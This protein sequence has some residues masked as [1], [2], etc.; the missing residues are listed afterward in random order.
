MIKMAVYRHL[1]LLYLAVR[2]QNSTFTAKYK[3]IRMNI[4]GRKREQ[5][6]LKRLQESPNSEFVM[7]Y[8]RRRVGKTYLIREFFHQQ[9]DFYLTGIA[10]GNRMEQLLNF[11]TT[12]QQYDE[13]LGSKTPQNWFEAFRLLTLLLEKSTNKRKV[14]FLDELPW[15]DTSKS[16]FLKALEHFWNT[17]ASARTDIL[18]IVCGSAASWMVK[19]IVRNHGGLHNRLTYKM[20]LVPFTLH[21]TEE[22]LK[23]LGIRWERSMIAECYMILGGIPY[24]LKLLDKR[25]SLAQNID[26]LFFS[27]SALLEDEFSNLYASLFRNS[28]E[29]IRIIEALAKKKSGYTREEI[30]QQ[31]R[32]SDGGGFSRRLEELEQCGFIRKYRAAGEVKALYQLIDF[33][34]LFYFRFLKKGRSFDNDTWMHLTGTPAYTTWCGLSFEHL[35]LA[36]LEQLKRALGIS[37]ISTNTFAYYSKEAQIDLLID[38][39]DKIMTLCEMKFTEEPFCI[40]KAY[41]EKLEKKRCVVRQVMKRRKGI[42]IVMV[43]ACGLKSNEYAI[44]LVQQAL[45]LNDLFNE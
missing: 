6:E 28:E 30:L 35:C 39:G 25:L 22:Y 18:L 10:H 5:E 45:T 4:I 11:R 32:I 40:T 33:Y 37:G 36:H 29:Y 23:E 7:V 24:Y 34:S 26:R 8:G 41:A 12:L 42:Y 20:K 19:N 17:W 44:N 2:I 43:T 15:I 9:F 38:R 27:E 31:T 21:E 3:E 16:D 1:Y 13:Q 14:V